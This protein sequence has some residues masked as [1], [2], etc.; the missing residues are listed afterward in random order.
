MVLARWTLLDRHVVVR[1][2]AQALVAGSLIVGGPLAVLAPEP[3]WPDL[4]TSA[5]VQ[6]AV[7]CALPSVAAMR[8]L[9]IVGRGTPLPY[10]PPD[11][12]VTSG[13]YAYVRNPMQISM[14]LVFVALAVTFGDPRLLVPA[15]AAFAYSAGLAA[16][17]EG[18]Q[19]REAFGDRWVA[20]R[21]TVPSWVPR[22]RPAVP[23]GAAGRATLWV[24]ADC[25]ICSEV[26][27]WFL[28][29]DLHGLEIR[30]A[31][32]HPEVLYRVTYESAGVRAS[33]VAAV[34]RALNHI[35]LRWAMAGWA[36]GMPG[37]RHLVQLCTDAFGAGPRPS[38]SSVLEEQDDR[39][40]DTCRLGGAL[41]LDRGLHDELQ[42]G[43][44]LGDVAEGDDRTD[45]GADQD[46]RGETHLV[47]AV[48]E[49]RP[50]RLQRVDAQAEVGDQR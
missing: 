29:H 2:W 48:V 24:A 20:Y 6:I 31:A 42:P 33:G 1:G 38:R 36:L 17:H 32:E 30:P 3:R 50:R 45:A 44:Q 12:L 49:L 16:W 43:R 34:A 21:S 26:G 5:G 28:R 25:G 10:D 27:R 15:V 7:V 4:V 22:W 35:D 41:D 11:R 18:A 8:E 46:G 37:V 9:A 47:E 39:L 40:G 23:D 19:L 13:P 14:V